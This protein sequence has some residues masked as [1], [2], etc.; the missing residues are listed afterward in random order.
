MLGTHPHEDHIGGLVDVLREVPVRQALD[1]GYAHGTS[2][3]RKYLTLL[4][5]KGVKTTRA[6]KG[7]H[8]DLGDGADLE[9]LAPEDPLLKGTS[10]D[11][12]NNSIVAR[13][14]YGKTAFLFTG[15]MEEE[16][17]ARLLQS[18]RAGRLRADVLK[19][20]HHGSH[21]GTDAQFLAVVQPRYAVI[22][23]ARKN[24]YGHPH[25]EAL[26][27]LQAA[28]AEI[29]RTDERGTIVLTSDGNS[30]SLQGG[31]SPSHS[32]AGPPPAGK[33]E[34]KSNIAASASGR[35][36]GNRASHVYHAPDCPRLPSSEKRVTFK[37]AS[38][39]E[40]AGY[41]PHRACLSSAGRPW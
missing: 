5:E 35:V 30:V 8:Y 23:L 2:L 7:Q 9:I 4:K 28:R 24:D 13:L 39:A 17:R 3:Q 32:E 26:E 41:H 1:P 40:Q 29:L 22:S 16:E 25:R 34:G 33:P 11:P 10:S 15:D 27:A 31:P 21:N 36:I 12:N 37:S 38:E 6:R 18:T 20:A 14:T 19:V